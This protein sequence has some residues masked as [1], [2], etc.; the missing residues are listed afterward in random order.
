MKI[1]STITALDLKAMTHNGLS[2]WLTPGSQH[3][4]WAS[5]PS[6]QYDFRLATPEDF[7][8]AVG[9]DDLEGLED[10][11]TFELEIEI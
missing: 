2:L 9:L 4:Y 8:E 7:L 5:H 3:P 6:W 11:H 1:T 10:D